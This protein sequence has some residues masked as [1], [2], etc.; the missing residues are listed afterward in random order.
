MES[1][2]KDNYNLEISDDHNEN[3]RKISKELRIISNLLTDICEEGTEYKDSNGPIIKP[4]ISKKIPNVSIQNYLD[5]LA[6]YSKIENNTL[7]LV[8]IYIDRICELNKIRLNYF[9]IHKLILGGLLIAIKYNEDDYFSNI[10]YSKVG[11]VSITELN[12]LEYEF[13]SLID[14]DLYVDDDLYSK[15]SNYILS[16]NIDE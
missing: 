8:L 11:G 16:V 10:F 9:N 5:R 3:R 13:L 14:F 15:Y 6:K 2:I 4:F 12:H 1:N 7:L